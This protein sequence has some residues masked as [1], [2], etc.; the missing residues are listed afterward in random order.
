MSASLERVIEEVWGTLSQVPQQPGHPWRTPGLATVSPENFPAVRTVVLRRVIL[1][2]FTLIAHT[3]IRSPKVAELRARP[4]S[5]WLFYDPQTQVQ[6]RL[7]GMTEI[8]TAGEE[9]EAAWEATPSGL[10]P[11]YDAV[12]PPG[13]A[14]RERVSERDPVRARGNF[15]LLRSEIHEADWLQLRPPEHE[16]IVFTLKG[17]EWSGVRVVP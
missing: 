13:S 16:R 7:R 6:L 15:G 5:E 10:R 8:V 1:E 3:D 11:N 4:Q 2:T 9:F 12:D 17:G 14:W